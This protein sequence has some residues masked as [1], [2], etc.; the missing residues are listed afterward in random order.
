MNSPTADARDARV[1]ELLDAITTTRPGA[2]T[3]WVTNDVTATVYGQRRYEID[4]PTP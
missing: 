1:N 3:T 2:T 4:V